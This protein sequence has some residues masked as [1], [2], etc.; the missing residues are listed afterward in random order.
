MAETS[1]NYVIFLGILKMRKS[2]IK[3]A[4]KLGQ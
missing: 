4:E 3:E 1:I 2:R